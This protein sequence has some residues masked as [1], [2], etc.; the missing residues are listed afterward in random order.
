[1]EG[2]L[3]CRQA[4]QRVAVLVLAQAPPAD[5]LVLAV[6]LAEHILAAQEPDMEFVHNPELLV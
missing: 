6:V 4:Q 1:M 5:K 3:H 2:R